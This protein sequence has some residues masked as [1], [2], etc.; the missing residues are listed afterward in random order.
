MIKHNSASSVISPF[1]PIVTL[2]PKMRKRV[3][4][5]FIKPILEI[6]FSDKG[7]LSDFEEF[8]LDKLKTEIEFQTEL[9]F[10]KTYVYKE[11]MNS[12]K[13]DSIGN[14]LYKPRYLISFDKDLTNY[15][16]SEK[17]Y[18]QTQRGIR[19]GVIRLGNIPILY[20]IYVDLQKI[21][22][23]IKKLPVEIATDEPKKIEQT[24]ESKRNRFIDELVARQYRAYS[25]SSEENK[26]QEKTELERL[27]ALSKEPLQGE[28]GSLSVNLS[29]NTTD[30][31]DLH[32]TTE[33]GK[34]IDYQNKILE[35]D[36][37]IGKLDVDA[38]SAVPSS[39]GIRSIPTLMIF[40]NG[41]MVDKIV[42]AVPKHI[43]TSKLEAQL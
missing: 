41:K 19:Y 23:F 1:N 11:L 32:I 35:Y 42:G 40:K 13:K 34:K 30:D 14:V 12:I 15:D 31:L 2:N 27:I 5:E 4:E 16:V 37:S 9:N 22:R 7:E 17:K 33:G 24:P 18:P 6:F 38:N 28:R 8:D 43:L 26:L 10:V 20:Y 3:N 29:W 36:G 39:F 25:N 21:I